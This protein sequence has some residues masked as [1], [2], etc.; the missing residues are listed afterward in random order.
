VIRICIAKLLPV[1]PKTSPVTPNALRIEEA[2]SRSAPLA[3]LQRLL[4]ESNARFDAVRNCLPPT[5]ALHV[6]PG[7][8]DDEGW[9][10]L[11]ANSAVASKLRQLLPRMEQTLHARGWQV[12][13]IRVKVQST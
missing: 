3:H 6:K 11:A 1:K 2:L 4:Q 8:V 7:P 13:A 10:L 12:T 5:L 9:S